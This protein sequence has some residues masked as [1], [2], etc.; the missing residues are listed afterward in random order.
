MSPRPKA[1]E[2]AGRLLQLLVEG[3]EF[4]DPSLLQVLLGESEKS[5][6]CR[7]TRANPAAVGTQEQ[8]QQL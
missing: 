3:D 5:S 2:G 7:N 4:Q 8:I 1:V 6:S